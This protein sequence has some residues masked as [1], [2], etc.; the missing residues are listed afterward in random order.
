MAEG[1][2]LHHPTFRSLTYVVEDPKRPYRGGPLE[3]APCS[4]SM[5]RRIEHVGKAYHLALDAEGDVIVSPEIA[6]RIRQI[7][8]NAGLEISNPVA[9]PPEIVL[10]MNGTQKAPSA[11]ARFEFPGGR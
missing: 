7:P 9:E 6:A 8:T 10:S 5:G 1:V 11:V 4:L 3:C 2:R